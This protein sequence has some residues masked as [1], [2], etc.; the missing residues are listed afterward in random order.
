MSES[1]ESSV[2]LVFV[3]LYLCLCR[4]ICVFVFVLWKM[5]CVTAVSQAWRGGGGL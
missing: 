1:V 3:Y 5:F 2:A 4:C